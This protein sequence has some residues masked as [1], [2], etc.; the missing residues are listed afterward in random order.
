MI[1]HDVLGVNE[2]D[3]TQGTLAGGKG[4]NP[5]GFARSEGIGAPVGFCVTMTAEAP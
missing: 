2:I 5:G 3:R 1:D 4:T